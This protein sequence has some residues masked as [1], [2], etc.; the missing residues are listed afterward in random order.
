MPSCVCGWNPREVP[1]CHSDRAFRLSLTDRSQ[2]NRWIEAKHEEHD[3][4]S[5]LLLRADIH[6]LFDTGLLAINPDT[7]KVEVTA[8]LVGYPT[9]HEF[10]G[11][12]ISQTP[13]RD[14]LLAAYGLGTVDNSVV[15]HADTSSASST[16]HPQPPMSYASTVSGSASAL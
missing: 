8:D 6:L 4:D 14:A 11:R 13:S 3:V 9:Y 2:A 10:H 16:K 1:F 5:G 7:R 12:D 15:D